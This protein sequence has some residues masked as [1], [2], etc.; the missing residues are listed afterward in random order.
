MKPASWKEAW[1]ASP[2][3]QT[4]KD[5]IIVFIKAFCMGIAD[6][7]PGVSGGTIAFITGIYESLLNAV[8][9]INRRALSAALK[10]DFK[11]ALS[12]LHIRFIL[13]VGIGI[14]SAI[15]LLSN[16]MNYLMK[17]H[18]ILTWSAFFG[19]IAASIIVIFRELDNHWAPKNLI[20]IVVGI[21]FGYAMVS[22]IPVE[23]PSE[24]WFIYL[25]GVI[26]ITAMILPGLSGSF[27][28][29][30]LGKYE[31][32]TGAIKNV[33]KFI[34][35]WDNL[36]ILLI[37]VCGTATGLLGFSNI[38]NWFLKHHRSA[39]MA[40]LTGILIGS[41][42]KVWPWKEVLESVVIRGKTRVIKEVNIFPAEMTNEVIFAFILI[43]LCF[44]AVL[45]LDK[46]RE[47]KA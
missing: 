21:I 31:Y 26:G 10:F 15:L 19:L 5:Y 27:L 18:T 28:L 25:C 44:V 36:Q 9:S 7:I 34:D 14:V 17:E 29:L 3:P 37:F 22:L 13:P 12:I 2:G 45:Y 11:S 30:I 42:K 6:I 40:F 38:L 8:S 43:I 4:K 39:T 35:F 41:M 20:S 32:I 16:L 24:W 23:T 1:L 46:V 33:T 47:K